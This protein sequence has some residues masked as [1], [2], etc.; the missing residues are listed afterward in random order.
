MTFLERLKQ[1]L[2]LPTLLTSIGST[3]PGCTQPY[4]TCSGWTDPGMQVSTWP[5]REINVAFNDR[6]TTGC[7]GSPGNDLTMCVFDTLTRAQIGEL[8]SRTLGLVPNP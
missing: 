4:P 7:G 3:D 2:L 5:R 8:L 6:M 1:G